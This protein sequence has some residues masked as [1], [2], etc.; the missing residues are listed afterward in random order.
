MVLLQKNIEPTYMGRVFGVLSMLTSLITPL[1]MLG[2]GPLADYVKI[3]WILIVTGVLLI[4]FCFAMV[5]N[6]TIMTFEKKGQESPLND[7]LT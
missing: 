5:G 7:S 3:E 1:S 2:Y 4:A 6:K